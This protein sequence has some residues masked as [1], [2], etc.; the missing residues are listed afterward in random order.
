[1]VLWNKAPNVIQVLPCFP[2]IS[3]NHSAWES[4]ICAIT[5]PLHAA[6]LAIFTL[7]LAQLVTA[8]VA[9]T[10]STQCL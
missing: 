5:V 6:G 7:M 1:M 2:I 4:P 9:A 3:R 10:N 8:A